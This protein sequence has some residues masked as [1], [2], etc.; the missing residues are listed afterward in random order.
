MRRLSLIKSGAASFFVV[1]AVSLAHGSIAQQSSRIVT[2]EESGIAIARFSVF[3]K[4]GKMIATGDNKGNMPEVY[5]DAYPL[6]LRSLGYADTKVVSPSE[7]AIQ[8]KRMTFD[9]PEL[10]VS[11]KHRPILHMTGYIREISTMSS[12]TDTLMLYREK[13]V[14]FMIPTGKEKRFKGWTDPRILKSKSYYRM[15]DIW[16]H[17]S[18][19]DR[20]DHHFSWSDWI[21]LPRRV[22]YPENI[23]GSKLGT[24]TIMGRYSPAEIWMKEKDRVTVSVDVLADTIKRKWTPRLA[25]PIWRDLDFERMVLE[26]GYSDTD[27]F[28]VKPE[29]IDRMSCYVESMGRGHSMFRFHHKDDF[30]YVTTYLDLTITDREYITTKEARRKEKDQLSAL[31]DATLIFQSEQMP[32][33]SLI[34]D[35][36]ARVNSIDHDYR[37]LGMEIDTR[38][39]NMKM[40]RRPVYTKKDKFIRGVKSVLSAFGVYLPD[41]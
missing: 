10:N 23:A 39:G 27:T 16:G 36:I 9:L 20:S 29:N 33:D 7:T 37:R 15:T 28:A 25:G 41:D 31:E 35:L 34:N 13:W 24:D 11:T 40:P 32:R 17:D 12:S 8:M 6:T 21:S 3:D 30:I 2:D 5:P 1:A 14:D 38:V 19:S 18:V 26:Y 22:N 4:N